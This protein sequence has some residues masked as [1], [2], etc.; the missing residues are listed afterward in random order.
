MLAHRPGPARRRPQIK[1]PGLFPGS[2]AAWRATGRQRSM[3][4][5]VCDVPD[6]IH[7]DKFTQ[8]RARPNT[9]NSKS[10]IPTPC[11]F[12]CGFSASGPLYSP[13]H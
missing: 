3:S 5:Q 8:R 11:R 1:T 10:G 2:V 7:S 6:A 13:G 9:P 12:W 4:A